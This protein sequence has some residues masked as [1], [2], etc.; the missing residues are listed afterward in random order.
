M[1][2]RNRFAAMYAVGIDIDLSKCHFHFGDRGCDP[3][4]YVISTNIRRRHLTAEDRDR[5][6]DELLKANP[7]QSDRQIAKIVKRDHKTVGS[8]RAKLEGRGEIP[9]VKTRTDTKGRKQTAYKQKAASK[10]KPLSDLE[11]K[12]AKL[13]GVT[14]KEF[15]RAIQVANLPRLGNKAKRGELQNYLE[16]IKKILRSVPAPSLASVPTTAEQSAQERKNHY[17]DAETAP[18]EAVAPVV[19]VVPVVPEAEPPVAELTGEQQDGILHLMLV[20]LASVDHKHRKKFHKHLIEN[21]AGGVYLPSCSARG[22]ANGGYTVDTAFVRQL[23]EK[24][25]ALQSDAACRLRGAA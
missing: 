25:I 11:R 9:H 22:W 5:L 8:R 10:Q 3:Y 19:E 18:A 1:D 15:E 21:S 23:A 12:L 13:L 2:G 17:A 20:M 14:P 6:A 24:I 16:Q 4:A 7:G